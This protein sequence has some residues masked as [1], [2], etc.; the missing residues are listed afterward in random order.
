M[1]APHE[2]LASRHTAYYISCRSRGSN[3]SLAQS[4]RKFSDITTMK[5][6]TPGNTVCHQAVD[7]YCRPSE[8]STPQAGVGGGMPAPRKLSVASARISCPHSASP[9]LWQS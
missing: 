1:V 6:P 8:I 2:Y 5:M 4:P 9:P 3:R 7:T